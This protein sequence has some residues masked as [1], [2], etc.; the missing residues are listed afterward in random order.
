MDPIVVTQIPPDRYLRSQA[1]AW[2]IRAWRDSFP[3]DTAQWYLNLYKLG[4]YRHGL[5][6]TVAARISN[7]L[8]GIG[9]LVA[10]DELPDAREPGPWLAAV[11]VSPR[12]RKHGAGTLIVNALLDQAFSLGYREVFAYTETKRHWYEKMGWQFLRNDSVGDHL[13]SVIRRSLS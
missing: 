2:S 13:V 11:F 5:P 3:S 1:A 9:S 6:F 8:V 4:D 7:T 12:F 10:D